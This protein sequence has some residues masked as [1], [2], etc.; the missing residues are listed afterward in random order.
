[1]VDAHGANDEQAAYWE[2]RAS[3]WIEAEDYTS[4]VTGPFGVAAMDALALAPGA[5]VLDVGCG[6]GPTTR[7]LGR[8]VAPNGFALGI[9]IAPPMLTVARERAAREQVENVEFQAGD[10]QAD[11]LGEAVYD[12]VFSRFGVMFFEDPVA[13]FGNLRRSLRPGGQLAF[14]CWQDVFQN[15][16][17]LV[18]AGAVMSAT[19]SLPPMPGPREPGPFSLSEPA[20]VTEVLGAAGFESIEVVPLAARVVVGA[21][22]L[23]MVVRS[24][25][26]VGA[27]REA[28]A[29]TDDPAVRTT[30][31]AAVRAALEEHVQDGELGLASAG[32]IVSAHRP[33]T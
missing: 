22:R 25:S 8:R 12:A 4:L 30:I 10:A 11:D 23:D 2:Q 9:D 19:G 26:S 3:S 31:L 27:V 6:T 15:E 1:M 13:A 17:M 32:W 29:H 21:D 20:H 7:E 5:R 16:W 24:A 14:A 28:F 33:E 18:P